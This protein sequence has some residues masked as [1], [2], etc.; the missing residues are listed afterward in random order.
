MVTWTDDVQQALQNAEQELEAWEA[1]I[2]P[3]RRLVRLEAEAPFHP[4]LLAAKLLAPVAAT[5]FIVSLGFFLAVVL[6]SGVAAA[7]ASVPGGELLPPLGVAVGL[8]G[9]TL[10]PFAR[11]MALARA[12]RS[13][14]LPTERREHQRLSGEVERLRTVCRLEG[15]RA[16]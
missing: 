13:P 2:T 15:Q 16:A 12:D 6:S 4:L 3:A 8:W 7:V 10:V 5:L 9:V 1:A 14:L 11:F